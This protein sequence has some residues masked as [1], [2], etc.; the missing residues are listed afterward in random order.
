MPLI[1]VRTSAPLNEDVKE[2]CSK[3]LSHICS[4][5]L[6]K[7]EQYVMVVLENAWICM[8][9]TAGSGAF[10]DVR[11]IGNLNPEK[12]QSLSDKICTALQKELD[13]PPERIYLNFTDVPR[14]DWGWNRNTFG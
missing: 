14:S 11:S 2:C 13:L 12:N 9:G 8:A 4:D 6:G 1:H 3:T 5:E 7:P 10:V